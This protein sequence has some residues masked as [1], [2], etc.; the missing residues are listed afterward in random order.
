MSRFLKSAFSEDWRKAAFGFTA[1]IGLL[2]FGMDGGRPL[3]APSSSQRDSKGTDIWPHLIPCRIHEGANKDLFVMTLGDT[4]T[5]LADGMFDPAKDEVI[6]NDGTVIKNYY[7]DSLGIKFYKPIDKS[8]FP[9]PPSGWCSW[10]YYYQE[11]NEKEIERNA[12][13]VADNLKDYGAE[14]IQIDDGWQGKG[15]GS[16]D[17]R[18]WTTID[19]RFS[20]GMDKLA[21]YIKSLGLKPGLWLAPHGQSNV[22]VVNRNPGAFILK[23]DTSASK[24]WEGNYLVDPSTNAGLDYLRNLFTTLTGWG[25]DYFKIDGQP[26]VID[27]YHQKKSFMQNPKGDPDSLY[28]A[29]IETI[30]NAIGRDRYLLGC[31]GIP[32]DGTGIMNG[33]R[34]GDDVDLGWGGFNVAIDATMQHYFLHNV[35]WYC[36]PDV[37]LL[38]YPLTLDQAR[39]WATL[40]GLTGEALMASD[41]MMDLSSERVGILKRVFPAVGIRPLDLFPS[42]THKHIWDLKINHIGRDYDVVGLFNYDEGKSKSLFLRWKDLGYEDTSLVQVFDFWNKEY[43]GEWQ[44]GIAFNLPPTSCRVLTLLKDNGHIQLISTNR[45]ITQGYVD[46]TELKFDEKTNAFHG[47]SKVIGNDPYELFFAFPRGENFAVKSAKAGNLK[48]KVLGHQGWAEVKFMSPK[49]A[50]VEWSVSFESTDFYHFAAA[51]PY[52]LTVASA[53]LDGVNLKWD[54][55]YYLNAGCEVFLDGDLVGYTPTNVFPIDGLNPDKMYS[56]AVRSVWEDGTLS[57][58]G[59]TASFTLMKLLPDEMYLSEM[60]PVLATAGWGSVQM[61][62]SVSGKRISIGGNQYEF[63]MGTHANSDIQ[64]DV[65]GLYEKFSAF[66]GIDDNNGSDKASVMF[67]VYGDGRELWHSDSLI[68]ASGAIPVAIDIK[69]VKSLQLKVTAAGES[70]DYDHADWAEA[71]LEKLARH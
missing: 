45:H 44:K 5:P 2:S 30:R 53:G 7:R 62:K 70:I 71:K 69:G 41:R 15:H 34:T 31:W 17:N 46:L 67:A 49:T 61:N 14:Y 39:A 8:S 51:A 6:L 28:R 32:L 55:Q 13:W 68:K 42:R 64:F 23:D 63:G 43:L 26:I 59:A 27:E 58:G 21:A 4:K 16:G 35:A 36:D 29:T 54:D 9:L 48:V 24:T 25:Y 57:S 66:V 37:M 50:E 1:I 40:Q 47:K 60:E 20:G 19:K 12:K 33:S 56:V 11:V 38:R 52:G 3:S 18:D 22:E 65:K 10:Y